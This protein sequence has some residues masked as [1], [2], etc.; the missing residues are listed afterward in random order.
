MTL[1]STPG[2]SNLRGRFHSRHDGHQ[3]QQR[4]GL[5]RRKGATTGQIDL[6]ACIHRY[7]IYIYIYMHIFTDT[8]FVPCL[9]PG[10]VVHSAERLVTQQFSLCMG[11]GGGHCVL[12]RARQ[13][14]QKALAAAPRGERA[15]WLLHIQ[16]GG[17]ARSC[18]VGRAS[19]F[20][21]LCDRCK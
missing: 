4:E 8:C 16:V 7:Y 2:H 6:Y 5:Q 13:S 11:I 15:T 10:C 18:R 12:H 19:F 21:L 14:L 20:L 3:R 9:A 1:L 17:L